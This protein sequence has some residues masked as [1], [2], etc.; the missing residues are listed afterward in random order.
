MNF[1]EETLL[2]LQADYGWT[3]TQIE[4]SLD[5]KPQDLNDSEKPETIALM[6]MIKAF[7]WLVEIADRD[8][9]EDY[10]KKMLHQAASN[11][12]RKEQRKLGKY[13]YIRRKIKEKEKKER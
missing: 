13:R 3:R 5:L 2:E 6:K 11:I 10:A 8:F 4:R 12:I 1:V 9:D 7:P